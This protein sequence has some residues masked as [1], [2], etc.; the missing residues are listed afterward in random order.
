M[1]NLQK[2]AIITIPLM[3]MVFADNPNPFWTDPDVVIDSARDYQD[4]SVATRRSNGEIFVAVSGKFF[5]DTTRY[6]IRVY[7]SLDGMNWS[8]YLWGWI[9]NGHLR[10]PSITIFTAQDSEYLYMAYENYDT[11]AQELNI[12]GYR[13]NL[14]SQA[15]IWSNISA[16]TN[17][18]EF[19]P[20]ICDNNLLF[21]NNP[22]LFCTF[23]SYDS[24]CF[25]RSTNYGIN[26]SQRAIIGNAG[27]FALFLLTEY[28]PDCA[29]GLYSSLD[30]TFVGV[31]WTYFDGSTFRIKFRQN[32][33]NG[34]VSHWRPTYNFPLPAHK[35]DYFPS[36][37]MAHGYPSAV[38]MFVRYDT[39]SDNADLCR[40]VSN[41]G[42][43]SW[44]CLLHYDSEW[45]TMVPYSIGVDDSLGYYHLVY[46]DQGGG[47]RYEK[48]RYDSSWY[49][50]SPFTY[51][52]IISGSF[53]YPFPR[54]GVRNGE[55]YV[56][57]EDGTSLIHKLKFDAKWLQTGIK[58]QK[59][60]SV[61]NPITI[62]PNP[63]KGAFIVNYPVK[64]PG[65][66]KINL[67]DITGRL[68]ASLFESDVRAGKHQ[69]KVETNN[70]SA[71]VYFVVV[72][73]PDRNFSERVVVVR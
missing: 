18:L 71:G 2:I 43:N 21:P 19:N 26:W 12:Y 32:T 68:V 27:L 11:V 53:D 9:P 55:P 46:Q 1:N 56:C 67:Y 34:L 50:W 72:S 40:F 63:A 22:L 45:A 36:L 48:A 16:I 35:V 10:N 52:G 29:F 3:V 5:Q 51:I 44:N 64:N 4:I 65:R 58:E 62:T 54:V 6:G 8:Q 69:T 13:R 39:L 28:G 15:E 30:S 20:D 24:V 61:P 59:S 7:R 41:D 14:T 17:L 66:V 42:G 73:T 33:Q 37:Q 25:L 23:F 31:T 60:S 57:W 70:L 49:N 47:L 38:I